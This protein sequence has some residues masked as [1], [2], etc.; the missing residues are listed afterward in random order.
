MDPSA[1]EAFQRRIRAAIWRDL[2]PLEDEIES[3]ERL[4]YDRL[5]PLLRAMGAFG[6][7]IPEAFGGLGLTVTQYL[8]ILAGFAKI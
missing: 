2:D 1:Y 3:T 5:M 4:P 8:P 6:P 7:L